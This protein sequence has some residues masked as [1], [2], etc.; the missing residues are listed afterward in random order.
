MNQRP[1]VV[2]NPNSLETELLSRLC[3][4]YGTVVV[5]SSFEAAAALPETA[6]AVLAVLDA[7]VAAPAA[8]QRLF[9]KSPAVI[10][11]GRDEARLRTLARDW[12]SDRHVDTFVLSFP[13]Q[14]NAQFTRSIERALAHG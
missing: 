6:D 7:S 14:D 9:G 11:T 5:A 1:I 4:P 3:R 8:A 10:I 2:L 12:P 13:V